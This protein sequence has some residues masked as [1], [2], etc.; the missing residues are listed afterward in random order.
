MKSDRWWWEGLSTFLKTFYNFYFLNIYS[1]SKFTCAYFFLKKSCSSVRFLNYFN[2]HEFWKMK[3]FRL[4]S[5]QLALIHRILK[6]LT[7][8]SG[9]LYFKIYFESLSSLKLSVLLWKMVHNLFQGKY[10]KKV[11][12]FSIAKCFDVNLSRQKLPPDVI[13][14]RIFRSFLYS[15]TLIE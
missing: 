13:I 10:T 11:P 15:F 2:K 7:S 12:K 9:D 14:I 3:K 8:N 4:C 5:R 6:I 1:Y